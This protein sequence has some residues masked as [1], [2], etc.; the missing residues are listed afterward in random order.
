MPGGYASIDYNTYGE[1]Y[2]NQQINFK[3]D[4]PVNVTSLYVW[5]NYADSLNAITSVIV[6]GVETNYSRTGNGSQ[7]HLKLNWAGTI[8]VSGITVH[9]EGEPAPGTGIVTAPENVHGSAVSPSQVLLS[10]EKPAGDISGYI[11]ESK[12]RGNFIQAAVVLPGDTTFLDNGLLPSTEYIYQVRAFNSVQTSEPGEE[13]SVKT[14]KGGNGNVLIALNAGGGA[15]LSTTGIEYISDASTGWV[16][17]GTSY[18]V[19]SPIENTTDDQL[20]QTERYGDFSYK[21]PIAQGSY[22]VVLKFAEIYHEAAGLRTFKVNI[23]NKEVIT[24]LDIFLRAG[25]N[26]PYDVVIPVD[27]SDDTLNISF[28]TLIDN[29]KL[30][31]LEIREKD[32]TAVGNSENELIT[33]G[34]FLYQNYPNPFNPATNFG[35]QISNFGFVSLKIFDVLGNEV[36]TLI[37]EEMQPGEYNIHFDASGLASGVYYYTLKAGAF[38]STK[39]MMVLK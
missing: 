8:P 12:I 18:S 24:K 37:R 38:M 5:D 26:T 36:A 39:K 25:Q 31:A 35:F 10:W 21:I 30:S 29:A 14:L 33:A 7:K 27:L 32:V 4:M 9:I 20:Y 11:I 17:G 28:T 13:I 22:S 1:S 15:F 34:Y 2:Q 3:P 19:S 23:E 16:T 6:N